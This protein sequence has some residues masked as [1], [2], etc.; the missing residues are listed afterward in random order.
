M[1]YR[2]KRKALQVVLGDNVKHYTR[3]RDYLQTVIDTNPGSICIFTTKVVAKHPSPNPRF[4]GMFY[5]L[6]AS[7]EGFLKGCRPFIGLDGCFVKLSTGQQILAT[8]GRDGNNN[9]YPI[10][11]GVVDKEETVSWS[12]FLTQLR[13]A[14]GGESGQFG[15]YTFISDRQKV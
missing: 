6:G 13:Y 15:Y 12:W 4:H 1:A 8:T 2:A 11:F 7:I 5:C 9:I 3:I 10:A 14:I